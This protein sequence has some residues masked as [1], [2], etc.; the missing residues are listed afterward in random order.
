MICAQIRHL[1]ANPH[2]GTSL[3]NRADDDIAGIRVFAGGYSF[4][5]DRAAAS[6]CRLTTWMQP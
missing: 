2:T 3:A 4:D 6:V 1:P 5:R